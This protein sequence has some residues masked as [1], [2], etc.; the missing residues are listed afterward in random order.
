MSWD[1]CL[2]RCGGKAS[3]LCRKAWSTRPI[4][5]PPG[6]PGRGSARAPPAPPP[7]S[8]QPRG[9]FAPCLPQLLGHPPQIGPVVFHLLRLAQVELPHVAR[10]PAIGDMQ[11]EHL[12]AQQL[13]EAR[14]VLENG[15]IG[16][17]VF[18]RDENALVHQLIQP[19]TTRTSRE[20]F[21]AAMKTATR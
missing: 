16:R 20:A 4:S 17:A 2:P 1:A 6:R 18:E 12:G 13:R 11:Q 7:P 15:R 8:P 21:R 10:R 3:T 9:P 5:T 14:D 19:P